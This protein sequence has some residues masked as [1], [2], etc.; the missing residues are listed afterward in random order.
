MIVKYAS[1][2]Y[3]FS[4][5]KR[6]LTG[7]SAWRP[8]SRPAEDMP[9]ALCEFSSLDLADV[10][11]SHFQGGPGYIAETYV[12]RHNKNHKWVWFSQ[13]HPDELLVFVNFD[14]NPSNGPRCRPSLRACL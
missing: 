7:I 10:A 5:C 4:S 1:M 14:S 11:S 3:S 8:L 6:P 12:L 2:Y 13:Q 9:L